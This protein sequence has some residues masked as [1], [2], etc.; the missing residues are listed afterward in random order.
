MDESCFCDTNICLLNAWMF[1]LVCHWKGYVPFPWNE[2][3]NGEWAAATKQTMEN[4]K[5]G[6][7]S[8]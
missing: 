8:I 6:A 4:G 5:P 2:A 3:N 7:P 1:E